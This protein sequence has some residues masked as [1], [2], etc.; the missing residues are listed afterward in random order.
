MT[1]NWVNRKMKHQ[2]F[3]VQAFMGL[4]RIPVLSGASSRFDGLTICHSERDAHQR[5][6]VSLTSA[7]V[8]WATLWYPKFN[9]SLIGGAALHA[10][11]KYLGGIAFCVGSAIFL[12]VLMNDDADIRL[13]APFICIFVVVL[14][15]FLWGRLAAILGAVAADVTFCF[16]LFPPLGSIRV[17][18]PVERKMLVAFQVV[19]I[20]L[21]F[22]APP[23]VHGRLRG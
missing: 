23:D 18:D 14:A 9:P 22:L 11:L 8:V 5:S 6:S 19:A 7:V 3:Q 10:S 12:S 1:K 15:A 21:S 13:A 4:K 2:R 20:C 16:V 17:N